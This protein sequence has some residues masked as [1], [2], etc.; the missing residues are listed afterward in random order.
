MAFLAAGGVAYTGGGIIY[1]VEWPNPLPGKFG[2]HEIWHI[3]VMVAA[4]LHYALMFY[5]VLP[6]AR[7]TR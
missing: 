3:F 5:I 1:T 4:A 7:V 6:A 2:F